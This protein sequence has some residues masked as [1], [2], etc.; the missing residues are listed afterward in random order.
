M[1]VRTT[2]CQ[3]RFVAPLWAFCFATG[4][5]RATFETKLTGFNKIPPKSKIEQNAY[6][7]YGTVSFQKL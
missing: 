1:W 3:Q 5:L 2:F 6:Y 4:A 7:H